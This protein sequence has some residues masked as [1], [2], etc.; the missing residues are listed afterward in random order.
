MLFKDLRNNFGI[1]EVLSKGIN[2][3]TIPFIAILSTPELYS[4][5]VLYYT[6]IT[7]ITTIVSFGQGRVILKYS[8]KIDDWPFFISIFISLLITLLMIVCC[9]IYGLN[10]LLVI[11]AYLSCFLNFACLKCR[12][13]EDSKNFLFLRI[14]YSLLR[15]LFV[16]LSVIYFEELKYYIFA[17]CL[18]AF[19][20][21]AICFIKKDFIT[22]LLRPNIGKYKTTINLSFP[23]F[24][25]SLIL[26]ISSHLDK[27]MIGKFLDMELLA[28]Y[29]I[30]LSLS[31]STI[32]L[33]SYFAMHY[34]KEIYRSDIKQAVTLSNKFT[35]NS[36]FGF[37]IYSFVLVLIYCLF[38][39]FKSDY[40]FYIFELIILCIS[41]VFN[42][43][44]LKYSYLL[45]SLNNTF[46]I[47]K[48][49]LY[50][51]VLFLPMSYIMLLNYQI[52]GMVL[53]KFLYAILIALFSYS[54][55]KKT[56]RNE[57]SS[58]FFNK[59]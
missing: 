41:N 46:L 5:V 10:Y 56:Y 31:S 50:S 21:L 37:F 57:E 40:G 19:L 54:Y 16:L 24:I 9:L 29:A 4:E 26:L 55:F 43:F 6:Y 33:F 35:K 3:F 47:F 32:F 1:I 28:N 25:Q 45:T 59:S 49:S 11:A 2:W 23:I 17:E 22:V 7:I 20:P 48:A 14:S 36:I 8:S 12:S 53:S 52:F 51:T 58:D 18:A 39:E 30:I 13:V 44:Y 27:I 38:N 42:A 15:S 34:E